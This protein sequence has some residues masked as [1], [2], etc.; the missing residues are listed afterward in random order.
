MLVRIPS[1][2]VKKLAESPKTRFFAVLSGIT[3]LPSDP[4]SR[5][6]PGS[7]GM[8]IEPRRAPLAFVFQ[9]RG[10]ARD[11]M[12]AGQM[13]IGVPVPSNPASAAPL[14]NK[15]GPLRVRL[16]INMPPLRGLGPGNLPNHFP[17][18]SKQRR[19]KNPVELRGVDFQAGLG[20][21]HIIG[22][23]KLLLDRPLGADALVE[24]FG[25]PTAG[26]KAAALG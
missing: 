8:S 10:G 6:N 11:C 21:D 7:G 12:S 23:G 14:K 4:P 13:G 9:R 1:E 24:S 22:V 20:P 16:T 15:K 3:F 5:S 2:A 18:H 17:F 26:Q 25:R 19:T